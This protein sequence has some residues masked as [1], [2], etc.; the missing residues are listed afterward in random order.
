[1]S[2]LKP[3][4]W[5]LL[6]LLLILGACVFIRRGLKSR[7]CIVLLLTA[8]GYMAGGLRASLWESRIGDARNLVFEQAH[9]G[10]KLVA[11]QVV[12]NPRQGQSGT[13]F[14]G[15]LHGVGKGLKA[16]VHLYG[17]RPLVKPGDSVVVKGTLSIPEA[18]KNP[19]EF[20][21]RRYL[22][23][24]QVFLELKGTVVVDEAGDA[25]LAPFT[26]RNKLDA[27]LRTFIRHLLGAHSY[28]SAFQR[29]AYYVENRIDAAF[30]GEQ[31]RSERGVMKA[32]LLGDKG[33]LSQ[34]DSDRFRA[35]GLYRFIAIAGFHVQL[36]AGAVER[37]FRRLTKDING[38]KAAGMVSAF[39]LAGISGWSVG[40]LRA[41]LCVTLRQ[42]AFRCRRKYDTLAACAVC[43]IIIGWRVPY[44][45][46]D[47]SFRLSFAGMI[48]G[49]VAREYTQALTRKYELGMVRRGLVQSGIMAAVLLPLLACHFHDV[50]IAG[51]FLGGLWALLSVAVT[52]C[53]LA[54]LCLPMGLARYLGWF[55]FFTVRG[56]RQ[57]G[58]MAAGL[59]M[60][61]LALP[62]PGLCETV[63]YL[64]LLLLLLDMVGGRRGDACSKTWLTVKPPRTATASRRLLGL[65]LMLVLCFSVG[66]RYY[67]LWPRVIFLSVGQADSAVVRTKS[68]VI[69]VD[70]GTG[71]S[72]RRVLVP[73][74]KREGV[75]Q[76]D[77]CIISHLHSDHAG[78]LGE[79]CRAFKVKTIMT[80][81]GSKQAVYEMVNYVAREWVSKGATDSD[82]LNIVEAGAGDVYAIGGAV[83][84]VIHPPRPGS[85]NGLND[86]VGPHGSFEGRS[87]GWSDQPASRDA[88]TGAGSRGFDNED[89]LVVGIKFVDL[90][91]HVEF[92]GDA[93]GKVV[94]DLLEA[95]SPLNSGKSSGNQAGMEHNE[96]GGVVSIIKVPHHG[97]PDSLVYGFYRRVQ[98]GVAVISVG[99][100]SYGH[101]S[102]EVI[103]AAQESK[104]AVFRTDTDGAVT[105]R[106][107]PGSVRVS[108]FLKRTPSEVR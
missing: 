84:T 54:V 105:V 45:L 29:L 19:G 72:A 21:Y 85:R 39:L 100:N 14:I 37:V 94:M 79:L 95:R 64:G 107:Y 48:A 65:I 61:S 1:M 66:L 78:G 15:S 26:S 9:S 92:W 42:L 36:A 7:L 27:G 6:F 59:P 13:T 50:S 96:P 11:V 57:I 32:L 91:A 68:A 98:G 4:V 17:A 97:S 99:P 104:L 20:D 38:S 52:L 101:P 25:G 41:F 49:W 8:A 74:L 90:S 53:V 86:P 102:P 83:L 106:I 22:M 47:M 80:C 43:S 24:K 108:K 103:Q 10:F 18:A 73:Y 40:P 23:G 28:T 30:P 87:S 31:T 60:A 35:A 33:D 93:P 89:S 58:S 62:A 46:T 5:V 55:P 88:Q 2:S 69:V 34:E 12:D 81:P 70:T 82:S 77:L 75:R 63:S 3:S 67:S 16:N 71:A 76:I 44:P 56:L 51:F